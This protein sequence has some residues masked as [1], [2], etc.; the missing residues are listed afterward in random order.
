MELAL[1]LGFQESQFILNLTL[2]TTPGSEQ[3][4]DIQTR[5]SE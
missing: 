3:E 2:N 4:A 1:V 5:F